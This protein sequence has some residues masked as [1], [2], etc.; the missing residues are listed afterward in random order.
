MKLQRQRADSA[1]TLT[2]LLVVI[3]IVAILA[4]LL[5]M[6]V[7][8]AKAKAL[9]IQCANN[10]RQLGI[11]LL[12]FATDYNTYPLRSNPGYSEGLYSEHN[13]IWM[14]ALQFTEFSFGGGTNRIRFSEWSGQGVWKCP[15]ANRPNDWAQDNGYESYGYNA[16]G[17]C[18]NQDTNCLG[19]GGHHAWGGP[20]GTA[21]P[22][23]ESE[24]AAPSDMMAIADGLFGNNGSIGDG[25]WNFW[26]S[27]AATKYL[28][29]A[30]YVGATARAFS[31]HQ[32]KA[33]VVFCDGHVESPTLKFLFKDTSDEALR[34]WNR[35]HLP[36]R[37]KL[38]P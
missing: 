4:A 2:E 38:S 22:V 36:H 31:R 14:T 6:A 24:I 8:Q 7:S 20:N 30:R 9:R 5:L 10:I 15:T 23:T 33:N 1:L 21:P 17:L 32:G 19:L 26:R 34:R 18:S 3:A 37:E 11:G 25:S 29:D 28:G 16:Y 13:T 27:A 12:A 35:D